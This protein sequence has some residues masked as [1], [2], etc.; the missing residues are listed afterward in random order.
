MDMANN[1]MKDIFGYL[2]KL[3]TWWISFIQGIIINKKK[4]TLLSDEVHAVQN[5]DVTLKHL[6]IPTVTP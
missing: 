5:K 1:G 2:T 4:S 6:Y 3:W